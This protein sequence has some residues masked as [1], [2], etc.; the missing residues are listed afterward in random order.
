MDGYERLQAAAKALSADQLRSCVESLVISLYGQEGVS[1]GL[2]LTTD[3][4]W[5]DDL[6]DGVMQTLD[7]YGLHP[8]QL[9]NRWTHRGR[10]M[11]RSVVVKR[12][13]LR[14]IRGSKQKQTA[15]A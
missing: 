14:L 6:L 12:P 1:G 15:Q 2:V 9:N 8:D 3:R 11:R 5:D 13:S 4:D 7:Q 10:S